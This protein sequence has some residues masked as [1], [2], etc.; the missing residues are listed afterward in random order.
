MVQN[1]GFLPTYVSEQGRKVGVNKPIK[2]EITLPDDGELVTGKREQEL[3]HLEG[4]ANQYESVSFYQAYP[5]ASRALAEWVV[6][7][8]N[9]GS[10]TVKAECAKAGTISLD[11]ALG[12]EVDA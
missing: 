9:A 11:L 12:Q 10:V 3:G 8:P 1:T 6:R 7:D 2:L 5:I 4:R